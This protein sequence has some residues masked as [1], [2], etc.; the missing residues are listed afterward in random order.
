MPQDNVL[1]IHDSWVATNNVIKTMQPILIEEKPLAFEDNMIDTL[2]TR[3]LLLKK[4]WLQ[5]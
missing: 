1:P 4:I 5:I 3:R 2:K